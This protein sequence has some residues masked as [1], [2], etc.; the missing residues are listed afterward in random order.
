LDGIAWESVS[1]VV[2]IYRRGGIAGN[3]G[4]D[5]SADIVDASVLIGG[6]R[7]TREGFLRDRNCDGEVDILDIGMLMSLWQP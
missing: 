7:R 4:P 5:G 2:D 3:D 1:I 6:F